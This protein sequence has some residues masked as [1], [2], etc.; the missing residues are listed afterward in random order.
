MKDA[1]LK[2]FRGA[3]DGLTESLEALVRVTRWSG[4]EVPPEPL[5]NAVSKLSERL[6]S[7]GRLASGAFVGTPAD[8]TKV[9][10]MC[11]TMKRLDSAYVAFRKQLEARPDKPGDAAERLEHDIAEAT[12]TTR[13]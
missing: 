12:A 9:Q 8:T 11:D 10:A 6:G 7:A 13:L 4:T 2:V 5:R 1:R 3:L